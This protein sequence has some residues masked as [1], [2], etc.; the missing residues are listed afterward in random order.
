MVKR[1]AVLLTFLLIFSFAQVNSAS[2]EI[3]PGSKCSKLSSKINSSGLT[4]TC[5]KKS[6]KL[7]WSVGVPAT[8]QKATGSSTKA[9]SSCSQVG[10][11][12]KNSI[13]NLECRAISN[14]KF[15]YFQLSKT[16]VAITNP[17]SPDRLDL[18]RLKDQRPVK[19][20]YYWQ[21]F[22][23]IA[24][25]AQ[26]ERGFKNT[27]EEKI[28]IA[29]MDFADA[30]GT[31]S[32]KAKIDEIIK[33]STEWLKWYSH[34]NLK[35]NFVTHDKW[36]R[37]PQNS[38]ELKSAADGEDAQITNEI[39]SEYITALDK[40]MDLSG[41]SAV[42]IIYPESASKIYAESQNRSY[43]TPIP[44]K[45]G[46]ISPLMLAIGYETYLSKATPWLYFVHETMHGQGLM[47]HSPQ[48]PWV[49]GI[50]NNVY[51]PSHNLNG[52]ES[53]VM[54]WGSEDNLYCI[55]K[56]NVSDQNITLVPIEREQ[57]G[58]S[59]VLVKLSDSKVLGI[60]SHRV[61]KWSP[62]QFPGLYGVSIYLIDLAID[63]KAQIT[64]PSGSYLKISNTNHGY[65]PI[66][67][68]P[69]QGFENFGRYLFNGVGVALGSGTDLSALMYLGESMS[70]EGLKVSLVKSGDNDTIKLQKVS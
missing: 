45:G 39:K 36:V 47:G 4:Y 17:N 38:I 70:I 28:I 42:W 5:I 3:K 54:G 32:P 66:R 63:N 69:I 19:D 58:I 62:F 25:P 8:N 57:V 68:T 30:P 12:I 14:G 18:C 21:Q 7:V 13:G 61:D 44:I 11:V 51:S 52:W 55:D 41:A 26:P 64:V 33:N 24:Y 23:A 34:G 43:Y 46:S 20:A 10:S 6:S 31:A 16:N 35:W 27:G 15:Q 56:N 60:E 59:T 29:G 2:A 50:M 37:A 48:W 1:I 67:G 9:G 22:R 40:V 65:S 53:L 49:F